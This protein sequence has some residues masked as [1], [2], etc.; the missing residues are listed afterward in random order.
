MVS[1]SRSDY[2]LLLTASKAFHTDLG[3]ILSL[4]VVDQAPRGGRSLLASS[5]QVYNDLAKVKPQVLHTLAGDWTFDTYADTTPYVIGPWLMYFIVSAIE[6]FIRPLLVLCC[7]SRMAMS[8]SNA[9]VDHSLA[10]VQ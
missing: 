7:T 3:D 9:H 5:W 2:E 4:Y 10:L 6:V 8:F 1:L